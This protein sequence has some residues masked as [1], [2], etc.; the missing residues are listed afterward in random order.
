MRDLGSLSPCCACSVWFRCQGRASCQ[1]ETVIGDEE[2][3]LLGHG[4][5]ST[6]VSLL[7][8]GYRAHFH[9]VGC[10]ARIFKAEGGAGDLHMQCMQGVPGGLSSQSI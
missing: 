5:F 6:P 9:P 7:S 1:R 3:S 4:W 8:T 10:P 2:K